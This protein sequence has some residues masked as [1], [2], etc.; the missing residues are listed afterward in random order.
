MSDEL[1][2]SADI[3]NN[4]NLLPIE[5]IVLAD[6]K[7]LDKGEGIKINNTDMSKR[8]YVTKGRCSQIVVKL[9]REG[10]LTTT[11][12]NQNNRTIKIKE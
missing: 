10:H 5:K 9:E 2:I 6:L 11:Y 1:T 8:Y 12:D 7:R 4:K 3:L